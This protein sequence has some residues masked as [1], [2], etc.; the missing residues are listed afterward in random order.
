[1][2]VS[3][4]L[5]TL[6]TVSVNLVICLSRK[7]FT[8]SVISPVSDRRLAIGLENDFVTSFSLS[9]YFEAL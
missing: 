5:L 2:T 9:V 3:K 1:M 6:F 7:G 4:N 8:T